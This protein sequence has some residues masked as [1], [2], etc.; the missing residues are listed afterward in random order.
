[1]SHPSRLVWLFL[2]IV[3]CVASMAAEKLVLRVLYRK[4]KR[5]G[6]SVSSRRIVYREADPDLK[7]PLSDHY[8]TPCELAVESLTR[9]KETAP[10]RACARPSRAPN[11]S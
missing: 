10:P 5:M 8:G 11:R 1:M 4:G 6:W 2:S 3:A 9:W 7:T